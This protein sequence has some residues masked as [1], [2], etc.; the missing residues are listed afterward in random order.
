[1]KK[2]CFKCTLL[3]NVMLNNST[4]TEHNMY[5]LNYIPA[6]NFLGIVASQFSDNIEIVKDLLSGEKV[7]FGNALISNG[8]EPSYAVPFSYFMDKLNSDITKNE[9]YLHHLIEKNPETDDGKKIQ[10]Q[11]KRSGF[12]NANSEFWKTVETN[13]ALKSA[14]DSKKRKSKDSQMYGFQSLEKGQVFVF[15]LIVEDEKFY[16]DN[17]ENNLIGE[18][19]IGKS[20]SAEYGWVEIEEVTNFEDD[21]NQSLKNSSEQ[22]LENQNLDFT[23]VYAESDLCFYDKNGQPTYQPTAK[24]LGFGENDKICWEKSQIRVRQYTPWNGHR[25]CLSTQRNC[26][27]KGSVFYVETTTNEK[28]NVVG[29]YQAE[30]LGRVIYNPIFLT[31]SKEEHQLDFTFTDYEQKTEEESYSDTPL[32]KFL[33]QL[34]EDNEQ[35]F[36]IAKVVLDEIK[37]CKNTFTKISRSQWG[38]IRAYATNCES[39]EELKGKLFDETNGVLYTGIAYEKQWRHKNAIGK[40]KE[41]IERNEGLECKFVIKF[42]SEMA[43]QEYNKPKN[44]QSSKK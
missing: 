18:R 17:I 31:K 37:N 10:L 36:K 40:L 2:K 9:I 5:T 34:K 22:S 25:G 35:E 14:Y 15:S 7:K 44:E 13:F 42:A 26:I 33:T 16:K 29:E 19:K 30:G 41:I 12:L 27:E 6:S 38:N 39:L 4:S 32:T 20:K 28:T 3:S 23:L 43:K 8:K 11:Q 21:Y 1:M 24:Q